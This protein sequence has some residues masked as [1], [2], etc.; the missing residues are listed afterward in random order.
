MKVHELK[1]DYKYFGQVADGKKLFEIRNNDRD[2]RVDDVLILRCFSSLE[3]YTGYV[4]YQNWYTLRYVIRGNK[5]HREW[6]GASKEDAMTIVAK[7]TNITDF[8]QQD[9]YVVLGIKILE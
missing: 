8:M 5:S 6:T 4:S 3:E 2:Y 9:G 7:V 1:L